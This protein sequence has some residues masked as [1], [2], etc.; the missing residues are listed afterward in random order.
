MSYGKT[1]VKGNTQEALTQ[2]LLNEH[3]TLLPVDYSTK[4]K[5]FWGLSY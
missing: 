4:S 2:H 5:L 1:N 3:Q